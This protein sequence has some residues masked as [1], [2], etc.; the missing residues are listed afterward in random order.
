MDHDGEESWP[1]GVSNLNIDLSLQVSDDLTG[2]LG[3]GVVSVL[4]GETE[5]RWDCGIIWR[6][7]DES[8]HNRLHEISLILSPLL[9][10]L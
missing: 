6:N 10:I 8:S 1:A 9:A 3:V 7:R 2:L 4:Q 5:D